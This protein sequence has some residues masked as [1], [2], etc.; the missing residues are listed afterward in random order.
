M[1]FPPP[2]DGD[3]SDLVGIG[4]QVVGQPVPMFFNE[5][6]PMARGD[7]FGVP[8]AWCLP[9][10]AKLGADRLPADPLNDLSWGPDVLHAGDNGELN[11]HL[12]ENASR[13]DVVKL[14][15]LCGVP[16]SN[17]ESA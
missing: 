2:F 5:R 13:H 8:L 7:S 1:L 17:G 10:N 6:L 3:A 14:C 11:S 12:Q 4:Q 16:R 9:R 15:K